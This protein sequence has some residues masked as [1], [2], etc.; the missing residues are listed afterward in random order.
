[1]ARND[2]RS[3]YYTNEH[4]VA[5]EHLHLPPP[6]LSTI[7]MLVWLWSGWT[8]IMVCFRNS[9]TAY[10]TSPPDDRWAVASY[11][12]PTWL[13]P[14]HQL[15]PFPGSSRASVWD[16]GERSTGVLHTDALPLQV[17]SPILCWFCPPSPH[18]TVYSCSFTQGTD[19]TGQETTKAVP[20]SLAA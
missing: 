12:L 10:P 20:S 15:K 16:W 3:V 2:V 17:S 13:P 14:P 8:Y 4:R 1:M 7:S 18:Q 6:Y 9:I 11:S 5:A 19:K